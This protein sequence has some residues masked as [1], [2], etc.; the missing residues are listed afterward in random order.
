M[1]LGVG[2]GRLIHGALA[3]AGAVAALLLAA[4]NA[5]G[6]IDIKFTPVHLVRASQSIVAGR[7]VA[8][9]A[10]LWRFEP[11]DA[12]KG[13]APP[14]TVLNLAACDMG[15][16][17]DIRKLLAQNASGPAASGQP[18]P[19]GCPALLFVGSRTAGKR[20]FLHVAGAWLAL[21][22]G[23]P[24]RPSAVLG[25]P[26][27]WDVDGL[28]ARMT[29]VYAGGTDMLIR[30]S[31]YLV[32]DPAASVPATV[33]ASWM[34][35]KCP[36]GT[37]DGEIAGMEAVQLAA[38][39]RTH[40]FVASGDGDR[41]FRARPN[42]EAFDDVTAAVRLDT[43]SRR[44]TWMD[45]AGDGRAGLVTWDGTA[46][47]VRGLG[48]DGTF[49]PLPGAPFPLAGECL[50]LAAASRPTDGTPAILVSTPGLPFLLWRDPTGAW[51][52]TPLPDGEAVGRAG[53]ATTA[54]VVADL[55]NDGFY[56]VLQPR[57]KGGVLWK[58]QAG[59]F[60]APMPSSVVCADAGGRFALGDFNQDGF[61]DVFVAG[62]TRHELWENDGRGGFQA[63]SQGAGSLGYKVG[64]GLSGCQVADL[65]HDGRPDLCLLYARDSFTYHFN[66]GFRCFGAEGG[67]SLSDATGVAGPAAG[68][69][70]CAVADFNGDGSLDLAVALLNG[71]VYCYYN[72][73]SNKPILRVGLAK[74]VSGPVTVGVWRGEK[75]PICSGLAP[76]HG[77]APWTC[78]CLPDAGEC[79]LRWRAAGR[80]E[81]ARTLPAPDSL[82][83]GG[84]EVLLE[85]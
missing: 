15:Q 60:A 55:D 4:T 25:A 56:D 47:A 29:A 36:L 50:G 66:R 72:D 35:D 13:E 83:E 49:R 79:T 9:E 7:L 85:P 71:Q 6:L 70:A 64:A 77:A 32:S 28:D 52:T 19:A 76:V 40:L 1:R 57:D 5:R 46:V 33:G 31:K 82:P 8:A 22:A 37:V 63:V 17:E 80:P 16:V 51:R 84:L 67:L 26:G 53:R 62:P 30:M 65:N 10:G 3:S 74:G 39:R 81:R 2:P 24:A 75:S 78:F 34:K 23:D 12:I 18:G 58:G 27:R 61:L 41:L 11:T 20:A 54:C 14:A 42:D 59:G 68:Q 44:F 45:L 69:K 38:D 21:K 43:R 73:A 48:E